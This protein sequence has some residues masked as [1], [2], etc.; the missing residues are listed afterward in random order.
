MNKLVFK[1]LFAI[2]LMIIGSVMV[3]CAS[4]ADSV[5][6]QPKEI[7]KKVEIDKSDETKY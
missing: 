1:I 7:E 2:S 4:S 6:S 5:K 3:S